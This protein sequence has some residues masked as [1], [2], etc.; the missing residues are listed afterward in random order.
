MVLG[1]VPEARLKQVEGWASNQIGML[2]KAFVA[3]STPAIRGKL[4]VIVLK[5]KFGYNEVTL[6]ATGR[7]SPNEATLREYRDRQV[8]DAYVVVQDVGDEPS[9]TAPGA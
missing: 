6:A 1:N 3:S 5:D 2:K 9:A 4:A 7:E 8:E